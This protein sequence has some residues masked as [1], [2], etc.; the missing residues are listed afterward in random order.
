[1]THTL[2]PEAMKPFEVEISI[3]KG[4]S[5]AIRDPNRPYPMQTVALVRE[6]RDALMLADALNRSI[7]EPKDA[8]K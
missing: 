4:W 1:M 5:C 7:R 6:Y 2:T 3:Y 8:A